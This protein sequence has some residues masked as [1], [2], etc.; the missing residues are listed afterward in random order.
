MLSENKYGNV[1]FERFPE[2]LELP[3]FQE[4]EEVK[5]K[6]SIF[7]WIFKELVVAPCIDLFASYRHHQLPRYYSA[8]EDDPEALGL[9]AFSYLWTRDFFCTLIR[10]G[11]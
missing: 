8:Y 1:V 3:V 7:G 6:P 2:E 4:V 11:H 9:N 5:L 10:R